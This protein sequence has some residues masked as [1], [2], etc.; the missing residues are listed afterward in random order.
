MQIVWYATWTGITR[1][2]R[3]WQLNTSDTRSRIA[4]YDAIKSRSSTGSGKRL[5]AEGAKCNIRWALD[6]LRH[7]KGNEQ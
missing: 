3:A 5:R 6:S 1:W 2:A 7:V 4:M